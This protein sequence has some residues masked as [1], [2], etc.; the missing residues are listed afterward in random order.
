M[1]VLLRCVV[2]SVAAFGLTHILLS[3]GVAL[4]WA[5][6]RP[7][8]TA[9][10]RADALLRL[11]LIPAAAAGAVLVFAAIGLYRFES[12]D[13]DE[14]LGWVFWAASAYGTALLSVMAARLIRMRRQTTRLAQA[15]MADATPL[16]LAG[17]KVPAFAIRTGFP[18]VAVIGMLRP[19]LVVDVGVL[20]ACSS[21]ELAAILAHEQGH[22]RRQDNLR[23]TLLSAVPGPWGVGDLSRA[24]REATE[25]AADDLASDGARDRRLHL[26]SALLRVTRL[27]PS[28]GPTSIHWQTQLPASAL[29][30]GESIE[31]R[32]RRLLEPHPAVAQARRGRWMFAVVAVA[33]AL[34]FSAQRVI[35]DAMEVV[36]AI[37]P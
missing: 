36:V 7:H 8:G 18:V 29:Y 13:G 25:E 19:R 24:W 26:A 20:D 9:A 3:A 5:W 11:H 17:V 21:D 35:H 16:R 4:R 37:L 15:W 6:R 34:A 22:L 33:G 14:V 23:R 10:E 30:R 2:L 12:R 32:V 28:A 31:H 1:S 27:A